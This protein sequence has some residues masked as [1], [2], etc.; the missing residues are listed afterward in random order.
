MS[1]SLHN[2]SAEDNSAMSGGAI[3]LAGVPDTASI[4]FSSFKRNIAEM[5]LSDEVISEEASGGSIFF[6]C[7]SED[8]LQANCALSISDS[9]FEENEAEV[10]GGAIK[11]T[12]VKPELTNN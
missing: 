11:W 10:D 7:G 2:V 1:F 4:T 9:V 8:A 12:Y 3:Y 6:S 5:A